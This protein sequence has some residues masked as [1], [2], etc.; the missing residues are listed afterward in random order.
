MDYRGWKNGSQAKKQLFY[1]HIVI[2]LQAGS[3]KK[4][5]SGIK[6]K[7]LFAG[8]NWQD[9]FTIL[10][11]FLT[12]ELAETAEAEIII[13]RYFSLRAPRTLR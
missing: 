6:F 3:P 9:S 7:K 11:Y 1:S 10:N 13:R 12:A 5:A 8:I 2:V 4:S